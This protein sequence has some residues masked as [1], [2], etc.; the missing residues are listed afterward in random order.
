MF[1]LFQRRKRQSSTAPV[2]S[3]DT[4]VH[5][6]LAQFSPQDAQFMIIAD[7]DV[8]M[9]IIDRS[10]MEQ[11]VS[12]GKSDTPIGTLAANKRDCV[13]W[14]TNSSP[15]VNTRMSGGLRQAA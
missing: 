15:A 5:S 10:S 1:R 6:A 2:M 11:A 14:W 3:S 12:S 7:R 8:I 13:L 4:P 9:G